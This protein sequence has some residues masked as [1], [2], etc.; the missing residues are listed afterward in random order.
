VCVCVHVCVCVCVCVCARV[1]V[2]VC[3]R[4]NMCLDLSRSGQADL[5]W[6]AETAAMPLHHCCFAL[7]YQLARD[8]S[9]IQSAFAHT[10]VHAPLNR[11]G[12]SWSR[13]GWATQGAWWTC[14]GGSTCAAR[15]TST[16]SSAWCAAGRGHGLVRCARWRRRPPFQM[17]RLA[18]QLVYKKQS[19]TI[20]LFPVLCNTHLACVQLQSGGPILL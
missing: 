16:P 15:C 17:A 5:V 6:R 4:V 2:C 3:A 19:L 8:S 20:D 14:C 7:L 10:A 11:P 18:A 1:C 12:C 13:A 9:M